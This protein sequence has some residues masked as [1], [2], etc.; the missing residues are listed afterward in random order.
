LDEWLTLVFFLGHQVLN[1]WGNTSVGLLD[2]SP[3]NINNGINT[4]NKDLYQTGMTWGNTN[5]PW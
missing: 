4:C 3:P 2:M 1:T 5:L